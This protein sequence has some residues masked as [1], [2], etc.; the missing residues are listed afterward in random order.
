MKRIMILLLLFSI[1]VFPWMTTAEAPNTAATEQP[2]SPEADDDTELTLFEVRYYFEHRLLPQR[3][4]HAPEQTIESLRGTGL[5]DLWC[6]YTAENAFDVT[7]PTDDFSAR[8]ILQDSGITVLL[9]T[10]PAP[11]D[12][13][14]C[15]RIYLCLDPESG[16]AA[17][18]TAEYDKYDGFFDEGCLLCGWNEDGT[19]QY[20]AESRILPD[21]NDPDYESGLGE[22]AGIVLDLMRTRIEENRT[23]TADT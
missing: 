16:T 19:H 22:E 12:T 8:E 11:A 9:L 10:L 3:F 2:E 23:E 5:C 21:R 6:S 7:Y 14:L 17:Y 15:Y 1:V 4:Y 20:Y 18:Y 13:L